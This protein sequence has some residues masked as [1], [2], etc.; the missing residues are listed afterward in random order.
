MCKM[1]IL[2]GIMITFPWGSTHRVRLLL[3]LSTCPPKR[4]QSEKQAFHPRTA[5]GV[6]SSQL[7]ITT[8]WGAK[9]LNRRIDMQK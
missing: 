2:H 1:H 5:L 7:K 6:C 4:Q 3:A 9:C 8:R